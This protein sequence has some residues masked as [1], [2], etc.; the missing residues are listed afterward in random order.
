MRYILLLRGINVGGKNKVVMAE[1]RE[2]LASLGYENVRSY[3]NSGN[4]F[5]ESDSEYRDILR[6]V[7]KMLTDNYNFNMPIVLLSKDQFDEEYAQLPEW[8][9]ELFARQDILFYTDQVDKQQVE[10]FV[11]GLDLGDEV[12]HI[13]NRACYWG[14]YDESSYL[15]TAYQKHL[16]KAP[17]YKGI[18]IRNRKTFEKIHELLNE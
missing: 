9:D 2:Q 12:V 18:T 8:W 11:E 4:L 1:I 5:F 16:L 14:K 10:E 6:D 3:I 15:K 13:G 7:Q 17:F